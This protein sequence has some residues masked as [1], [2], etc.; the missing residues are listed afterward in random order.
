LNLAQR[1][2]DPALL[3]EAHYALGETL[4]HIGEL[5]SA[6][7]HVEQGIALYDP[8]R[9]RSHTFL[10][11]QNPGVFCL[12]VGAFALWH[13]GYPDQAL[14]RSQEALTLA[15]ELSH[16]YS[17]A[18]A[19]GLVTQLHHFRREE[20]ITHERAEALIALSR[21]QR[22]PYW[23]A[24][25][26]TLRGWVLIQREQREEAIAQIRQGLA[27]WRATRA[28]L[29]WPYLLALLAEA[30]GKVGQGEEGLSV[31]AEA[32]AAVDKSGE[33]RWEAELYRLKGEL[34]LKQCGVQGSE[35]PIPSP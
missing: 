35:S 4:F 13:L 6:R 17:L 31:L 29:A 12:L 32:L 18:T 1:I 10:Y 9:H 27:A 11:G 33:R 30:Y 15:Q 5:G 23:I 20:Q 25:G 22:F 14:Q 34:T 7:M 24:L 19:L 2:Q 21:E 8:Q 3:L 26:T 16:P 28:E